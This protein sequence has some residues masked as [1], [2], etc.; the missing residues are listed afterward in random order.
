MQNIAIPIANPLYQLH[1]PNTN[2]KTQLQSHPWTP[3]QEATT[4]MTKQEK[5]APLAEEAGED[6]DF[7]KTYAQDEKFNGK[8]LDAPI[9]SIEVSE[10]LFEYER[11]CVSNLPV[12]F[13]SFLFFSVLFWLAL[14][15]LAF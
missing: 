5:S 9:K 1:I 15:C 11:V 10:G 8:P 12:I 13:F 3:L 4:P 2:Y 6:D 7:C 14:P